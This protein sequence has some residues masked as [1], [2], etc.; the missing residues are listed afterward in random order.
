MSHLNH[1]VQFLPTASLEK[2]KMDEVQKLS[3][4][5]SLELFRMYF[6]PELLRLLSIMHNISV[7]SACESNV[8]LPTAT[9]SR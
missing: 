1:W 8:W 2:E 3:N 9:L 6:G 4:K 7:H 5:P